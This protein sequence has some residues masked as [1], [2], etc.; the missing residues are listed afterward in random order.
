MSSTCKCVQ[1]NTRELFCLSIK[2][3]AFH[4]QEMDEGGQK[5]KKRGHF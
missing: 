3:D 4:G 5:D 1:K 2:L